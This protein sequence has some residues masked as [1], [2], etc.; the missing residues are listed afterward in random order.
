M[1]SRG[2]IEDR[3]DVRDAERETEQK[4]QLVR[5]L[6]EQAASG[7]HLSDDS[8]SVI[9]RWAEK[10][11]AR[12]TTWRHYAAGD[13]YTYLGIELREGSCVPFVRYRKEGWVHRNISMIRPLTEWF[14]KVPAPGGQAEEEV[15]RYVP[16]QKVER[17]E[18]ICD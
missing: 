18:P 4:E 14:E 11:F 10:K 15:F 2:D 13:L 9:V 8:L 7:K 6:L 5:T 16:V 1:S 17:W 3:M 12:K